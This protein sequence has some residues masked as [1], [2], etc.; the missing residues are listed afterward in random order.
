MF[1]SDDY[2]VTISGYAK[3]IE[4]LMVNSVAANKGRLMLLAASRTHGVLGHPPAA[5]YTF[6]FF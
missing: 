3:F 2:G 5:T 4:R 6:L 1:S